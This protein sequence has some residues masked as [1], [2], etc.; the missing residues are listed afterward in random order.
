[1]LMPLF[2]AQILPVELPGRSNRLREAPH[3]G[4]Q[5]LMG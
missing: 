2:L 1:M 3:T 4:M 5:R